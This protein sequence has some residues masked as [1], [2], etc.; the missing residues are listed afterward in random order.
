MKVMIAGAT[1]PLGAAI[2]EH[3]LGSRDVE[4]VLAVGREPELPR[5]NHGGSRLVYR[6]A[7]LAHARAAHDVVWGPARELGI[8][9]VVYCAH[10]RRAHDVGRAVHAQNVLA[11]N[12]VLRACADHPSIH[13]FVY[14]SF[15]EVYA[16]RHAT[17]DLLDEEAPLE[18]A[19]G[20]PQWV[21]DRVQAD[22][23]VCTHLAGPLEI[24]VLRCAEIVAP[25][26]GS[27]LW[28]YLSS[29]VCLRPLGFDPMLDLLSLEDA[30]HAFG[31]AVGSAEIGVF[32]IPGYDRLPLSRAITE[33]MSLELPVPGPLLAPLYRLRRRLAGYDFRYDVNQRRFH[34]GGI[35]D[36]ARARDRLGY[37][38]HTA[39]RWPV[40][41]WRRLATEI[42]QLRVAPG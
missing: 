39:V 17:P 16:L 14:R 21:R 20:A 36:G 32:N 31:A 25:D 6:S 15:A 37:V 38:P 40:P 10:H 35:L 23:E 4:L 41:W 26:V 1:T 30:A 5:P 7:D 29:R 9:V 42:D 2:T 11:P 34:F 12:H 27:Q 22:L 19:P 8:E 24:A 33:S 3:L 18:L 28:D 13:R